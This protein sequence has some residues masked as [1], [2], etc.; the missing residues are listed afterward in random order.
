MSHL[1]DHE[2][3]HVEDESCIARDG[4][5]APGSV[6]QIT[7][8]GELGSLAFRHLSYALLPALNNLLLAQREHEGTAAVSGTV[9]LLPTLQGENIVTGHLRVTILTSQYFSLPFLP[10][11]PAEGRWRHL[12]ASKSQSEL[13]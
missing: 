1:L 11:V 10:S 3:L 8:D 12:Q 4:S 5:R 7:G 6:A 9:D 13:P 2:E